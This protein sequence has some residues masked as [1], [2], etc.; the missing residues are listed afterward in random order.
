MSV[1]RLGYEEDL[2]DAVDEQPEGAALYEPALH[3]VAIPERT[4][5]ATPEV[6]FTFSFLTLVALFIA[7]I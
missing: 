6:I 3:A 5:R 4:R 1:R 7:F 2:L